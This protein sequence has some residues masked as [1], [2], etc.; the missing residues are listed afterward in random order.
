MKKSNKVVIPHRWHDCLFKKQSTSAEEV[1]TLKCEFTKFAGQMV[2]VQVSNVC[3]DTIN[4]ELSP[5]KLKY[6]CKSC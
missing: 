3:L 1:R 4:K 5:A 6:H 2:N